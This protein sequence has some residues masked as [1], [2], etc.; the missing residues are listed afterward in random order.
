MPYISLRHSW[1]QCVAIS[2]RSA[3]NAPPTQKWKWTQLVPDSCVTLYRLVLHIVQIPVSHC[4]DSCFKSV[5]TP[6]SHFAALGK[7][8][9]TPFLKLYELLHLCHN[10]MK[11]IRFFTQEIMNPLNYLYELYYCLKIILIL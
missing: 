11:H 9:P 10:K 7:M 1:Y 8:Q 6:A 4:T 5:L 2:I 3:G